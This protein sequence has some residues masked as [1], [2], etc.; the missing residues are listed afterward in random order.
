MSDLQYTK[1]GQLY[2]ID[3]TNNNN[4]IEQ[5]YDEI[6]D[7]NDKTVDDIL[8]IQ[9]KLTGFYY[10]AKKE[11]K[12]LK[13]IHTKEGGGIDTKKSIENAGI[14]IIDKLELTVKFAGVVM[15]G[16]SF[17]DNK[18]YT[19]KHLN[20]LL[21]DTVNCTEISGKL[22]KQDISFVKLEDDQNKNFPD[23]FI[24]YDLYN[25]KKPYD[26]IYYGGKTLIIKHKYL[27]NNHYK[28]YLSDI[29]F[30][31]AIYQSKTCYFNL[32]T[33]KDDIHEFIE[34]NNMYVW[35]QLGN[36]DIYLYFDKSD[37]WVIG[38]CLF[39]N[40]IFCPIKNNVLYKSSLYLPS[41]FYLFYNTF[42]ELLFKESTIISIAAAAIHIYKHNQHLLTNKTT[43]PTS[44]AT[45]KVSSKKLGLK[46]YPCF[47][48]ECDEISHSL[49][50]NLFDDMDE[51]SEVSE[52]SDSDADDEVIKK[53]KTKQIKKNK[54][55]DKAFSKCSSG[56][57]LP[58]SIMDN[59]TYNI[60]SFIYQNNNSFDI[61]L[62]DN[63]KL[64]INND[65]I[66][67]LSYILNQILITNT[68]DNIN[69][70]YSSCIILKEPLII[71]DKAS[72]FKLKFKNKI[73]PYIKS[74]NFSKDF[75]F[76][77]ID[78]QIIVDY[79]FSVKITIKKLQDEDKIFEIGD[80]TIQNTKYNDFIKKKDETIAK[81]LRKGK[82]LKHQIKNIDKGSYYKNY[83]MGGKVIKGGSEKEAVAK[84]AAAVAAITTLKNT[85]D[86]DSEEKARKEKERLEEEERKAAEEK[87]RLEREK[88][89]AAEEKERLE[90]EKQEKERLER[91]K[92]EKERL[93]EEERLKKAR[94]EKEKKQDAEHKERMA[95]IEQVASDLQEKLNNEK[96]EK[97]KIKQQLTEQQTKLNEI[98]ASQTKLQNKSQSNLP[99]EELPTH[100]SLTTRLEAIK[101]KLS[102][103]PEDSED[104][105]KPETIAKKDALEK[106]KDYL[107]TGILL[108]KELDEKSSKIKILENKKN[109][110]DK[111]QWNE[112]LKK[113]KEENQKRSDDTLTDNKDKIQ[114]KTLELKFSELTS[115]EYKERNVFQTKIKEIVKNI[116]DIYNES[117]D[118]DMNGG[119][120]SQP[121]TFDI[122]NRSFYLYFEYDDN[123]IVYVSGLT[124]KEYR[125]L[126]KKLKSNT[127]S[128]YKLISIDDLPISE[129]LE[130]EE[131]DDDDDD[132]KDRDSNGNN[133][134]KNYLFIEK[135]IF[136]TNNMLESMSSD[137]IYL[138]NK[139]E[140]IKIFKINNLD[141]NDIKD[142]ENVFEH[143]NKHILHD[144]KNIVFFVEYKNK[145]IENIDKSIQDLN[146]LNISFINNNHIIILQKEILKINS[147]I[148]EL[149]NTL[150]LY[151]SATAAGKTEIDTQREIN[152]QLDDLRKKRTIKVKKFN[153]Y[154]NPILGGLEKITEKFD[155][156]EKGAIEAK[157]EDE[158]KVQLDN[159]MRG[160]SRSI[161]HMK[162]SDQ[163]RRRTPVVR[164]ND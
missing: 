41:I 40:D 153:S 34:Y 76:K 151:K 10:A 74:N 92:Q 46:L 93:E 17:G 119:E 55:T 139:K 118:S 14:I 69:S 147:D 20:S 99:N 19:F 131:L 149:H 16:L 100:D 21:P 30:I 51:D 133:R 12:I 81:L 158:S 59:Q 88:R 80:K 94:E 25:L 123:P 67:L 42:I 38:F 134:S 75:I 78:E 77:S 63:Q 110:N 150:A 70:K 27:Q 128:P 35:K 127:F 5:F 121:V 163:P 37:G 31:K 146:D 7:N 39:L 57:L 11:K 143:I 108:R 48:A 60:R 90:R 145:D 103:I 98:T 122:N 36:N 62:S 95:K 148:A 114:S 72:D 96:L 73:K 61:V 44:N 159:I 65:N 162:T 33:K 68:L 107:E 2:Y 141:I 23:N 18:S 136:N 130:E 126:K 137:S 161:R 102:E 155:E 124:N 125:Y 52:E 157:K 138:Y 144:A 64:T 66:N 79:C 13:Q 89:K 115:S 29:R 101:N 91:E 87:E 24:I 112:Q 56:S 54:Q 164:I 109:I 15:Y 3:F 50:T 9:F 156:R 97:E 84:T 49:N 4:I 8:Q 105:E 135:T 32:L 104:S 22:N 117:N 43:I 140:Y 120:A 154:V 83:Q 113:I 86:K 45:L 85:L 82:K 58:M 47:S 6:N 28:R 132:D 111:K 116:L 71:N 26:F 160:R 129:I 106:E 152:K 53:K 1:K 142:N